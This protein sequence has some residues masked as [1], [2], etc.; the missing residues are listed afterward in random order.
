MLIENLI[1]SGMGTS[2]GSV[3]PHPD[4]NCVKNIT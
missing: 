2:I 4:H 1:I 3:S